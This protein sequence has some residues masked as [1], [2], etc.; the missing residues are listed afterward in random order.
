MTRERGYKTFLTAVLA[1]GFIAAKI[2]E[3]ALRSDVAIVR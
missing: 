2:Y 3:A 1:V